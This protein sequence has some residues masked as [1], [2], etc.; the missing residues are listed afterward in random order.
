MR[1]GLAFLALATLA[2]CA[3]RPHLL[4]EASAP[5]ASEVR[6]A[7]HD[8]VLVVALGGWG[9]SLVESATG[10]E[11]SAWRLPNVPP[12]SAHELFERALVRRAHEEKFRVRRNREGLF[13]EAVKGFVN[14]VGQRLE[15]G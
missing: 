7:C 11:R 13:F 3:G 12:E 1:R 5:G 14:R 9:V 10:R 4:A 2:G 15:R 8:S 6:W